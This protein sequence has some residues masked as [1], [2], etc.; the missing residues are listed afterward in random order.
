MDEHGKYCP[1]MVAGGKMKKLKPCPFCGDAWIYISDGS[2]TSGYE[3]FGYKVECRCKGSFMA[4]SWKI[5]KEEAIE[6][7]NRRCRL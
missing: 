3:S 1:I 4:M 6:A 5:T 7:W 2:Y